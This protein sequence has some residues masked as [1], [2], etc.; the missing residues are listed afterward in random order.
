MLLAMFNFSGSDIEQA[1]S[2]MSSLEQV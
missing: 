1:R 2:A